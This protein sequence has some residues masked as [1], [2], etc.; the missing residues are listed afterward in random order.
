M[1]QVILAIDPGKSG[2]IVAME[3]T[4][5]GEKQM[6]SISVHR[7]PSSSKQLKDLLESFTGEVHAMIERVNVRPT[8]GKV[9]AAKFM[10]NVQM[11]KTGLAFCGIKY[12]EVSPITWQK[13]LN[14]W[15]KPQTQ[16]LNRAKVIRKNRHKDFAEKIYGANL[17]A[18]IAHWNADAIL[19][20]AYL[21]KCVQHKNNWRELFVN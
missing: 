6:Q 16:D 17:K 10:A 15:A 9:S 3:F 8:D 11:I 7:M 2:A 18:K 5:G 1:R 21:W 13:G 14:V 12:F 19:L 20:S 4:G